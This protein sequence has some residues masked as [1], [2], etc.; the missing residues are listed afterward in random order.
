[1][2]NVLPQ[3]QFLEGVCLV[4]SL[5]K[6]PKKLYEKGKSWRAQCVLE[7]VHSDVVG[8]FLVPS[9]GKSCYVL[10][11]IDDYYHFT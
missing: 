6:H 10:A 8:P 3:V 2:V 5:G 1:M 7:L 11:C 9:F 4:F